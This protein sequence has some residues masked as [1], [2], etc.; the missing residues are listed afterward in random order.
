MTW[1]TD[2]METLQLGDER[3][4][5]RA[6][7]LLGSLGD[8]PTGSI[9]SAC[10][11]W[12]E[13]L[14]AYRFFD[15]KKVEPEKILASHRDATIKRMSTN[16]TVLLLQDTTELDYHTQKAKKGVGPLN[17]PERKGLYLHP[18]IA[19]NTEG[20]CLGVVKSHQW[21]R[22][23]IGNPGPCEEKPIEEKESYRWLESYEEANELAKKTS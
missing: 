12:N 5:K 13:T 4:H 23:E 21:Y 7:K 19:I 15:H 17:Y 14:A 3:P 18:T 2:E 9:P 11:G 8:I 6:S 1:A 22:E 10:N 20:L 16:E